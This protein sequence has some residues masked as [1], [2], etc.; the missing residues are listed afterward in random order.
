[1]SLY[2]NVMLGIY[3]WAFSSFSSE[4][5]LSLSICLEYMSHGKYDLSRS[6]F[7]SETF[8]FII[9]IYYNYILVSSRCEY[10]HD[11]KITFCAAQD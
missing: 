2:I 1:M 5:L 4:P 3:D 7:S 9:L 8:L 11:F 6:S 10:N